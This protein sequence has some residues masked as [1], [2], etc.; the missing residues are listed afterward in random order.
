MCVY[1]QSE[2]IAYTSVFLLDYMTF[3]LTCGL[4][5]VYFINLKNLIC[6]NIVK[7]QGKF[8]LLLY[9]FTLISNKFSQH[10]RPHEI[11]PRAACPRV[12]QHW[13]IR[14]CRLP[15]HLATSAGFKPMTLRAEK[16]GL[17]LSCC[18][19]QKPP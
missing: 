15:V 19:Q 3:S 13:P 5:T 11:R 17:N 10:W 6:V 16:K 18:R 4:R 14:N 8:C 7:C 9:F 12:G 2:I 1:I